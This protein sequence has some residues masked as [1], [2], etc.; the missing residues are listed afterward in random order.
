MGKVQASGQP[1]GQLS[2]SPTL[3]ELLVLLFPWL[4]CLLYRLKDSPT[5]NARTEGVV[6]RVIRPASGPKPSALKRY[7]FGPSPKILR[8]PLSSG[9]RST[10]NFFCAASSNSEPSSPVMPKSRSNWV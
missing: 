8:Y 9:A 5:V 2:D 7:S 1:E 4:S 3:R 6:K 10:P